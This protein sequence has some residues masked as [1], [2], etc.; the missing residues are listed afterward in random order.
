MKQIKFLI[1]IFMLILLPG[2]GF[3][4]TTTAQD[5]QSAAALGFSPDGV[6]FVG[7]NVGGAIYAF[8]MGRQTAVLRQ[9]LERGLCQVDSYANRRDVDHVLQAPKL[10]KNV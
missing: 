7:D 4:T 8:E 10:S 2:A 3:N 9:P 6:L 5:I 1:M